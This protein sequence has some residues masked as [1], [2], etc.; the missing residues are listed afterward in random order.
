M[1]PSILVQ[2]K[3]KKNQY[4]E[5]HKTGNRMNERKCQMKYNFYLK[6]V[7]LSLIFSLLCGCQST[8]GKGIVTSKNDGVFEAALESSPI[9]E[10]EET[11]SVLE[12]SNKHIVTN[13]IDC[14]IDTEPQ[15][16]NNAP[17]LQVRPKQ[18]WTE[19]AKRIGEVLFGDSVIYEY[20][21][22]K[23]KS[24]L[25]DLI[26]GLRQFISDRAALVE[27]YNGN[28]EIAESVIND[29]KARIAYYELAYATAPEYLNPQ[30]CA[31]EFH[32][33]SYYE[34][35]SN[36]TAAS[37]I[38]YNKTN[39]IEAMGMIDG[40][41]YYY[42]VFVRN[43]SDYRSNM[44][45]FY[46]DDLS[47]PESAIFGNKSPTD[48]DLT[49]A[50]EQAEELL[51]KMDLG[52]WVTDS[53]EVFSRM[54]SNGEVG[55][56]ITV[57]M[58]PVYE[59]IKVTRQEQLDNLTVDDQNASNYKYESIRFDFTTDRLLAFEYQGGL[60]KVGVVNNAVQLISPQELEESFDQYIRTLQVN[61]LTEWYSDKV[62]INVNCI[63]FGLCR[64]RIKNNQTDFYLVP[65]YTFY[66]TVTPVD[67]SGNPIIFKDEFGRIIDPST[68]AI[69]STINAVDGSVINTRLGY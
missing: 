19:T 35:P 48:E 34:D 65:A 18:I 43:E 38:S 13:D 24:E 11:P 49:C 23:S 5:V 61:Q 6:I 9:P 46:V 32:P 22:E 14:S 31:W 27:Y 42:D 67:D 1:A 20:S 44:A 62:K 28:E 57:N 41:P 29:Y 50:R 8:P 40:L 52:E 17:V 36:G 12:F 16:F 58:V 4:S 45:F 25:E 60:E 68:T 51:A 2:Y 30:L 10:T 37:D 26:L 54:L 39:T 7:G 66:G 33:R 59:G 56:R 64:T 21:T 63:E 53:C 69:L 15:I 3:G 55:Y 47:V